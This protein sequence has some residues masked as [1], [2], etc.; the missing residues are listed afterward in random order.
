M[1]LLRAA[2]HRRMPWKNGGGVTTEIAVFPK[3]AGLDDFE[4]R[5]S[6]AT[7]ASDGPFSLFAGVDRTLALLEGEGILLSIEGRPEQ[8]VTLNSPPVAFAADQA[9]SARLV[10]GPITDLNIMTR[11]GAWAHRMDRLAVRGSVAVADAG[12]RTVIF[13]ASGS[14]TISDGEESLALSQH[15]AAIVDTAPLEATCS[16]GAELYVVRLNRV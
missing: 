11:R 5:L 13:C 8:S 12:E 10:P 4:W 9:T 1:K 3:G 2:N 6:M 7:V 14:A 15:D 16:S